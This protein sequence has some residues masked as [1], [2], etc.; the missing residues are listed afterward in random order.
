MTTTRLLCIRAAAN[1]G[2][3]PSPAPS[4]RSYSAT[5]GQLIDVPG[6]LAG[7]AGSLLGYSTS[8]NTGGPYFVLIASSG[9]T[10]GR[11][12]Y[13]TPG[14]SFVDTTVGAVIAYDGA[15]WRNVVTGSIV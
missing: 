1:L 12:T 11:P 14:Q 4:Q 2:V 15:S 6:D 10:T 5:Q 13:P 9:P 8:S 7:D 3:P